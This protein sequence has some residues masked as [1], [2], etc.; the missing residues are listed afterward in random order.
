VRVVVGVDGGGTKTEAVIADERGAF[1]GLGRSGPS[2][3]EDVGLGGAGASFRV[4][5]GEALAAADAKPEDVAWGSL[6]TRSGSAA[7]GRS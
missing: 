5:V 3:W 1:L 6:S 4:A 2:N 7:A